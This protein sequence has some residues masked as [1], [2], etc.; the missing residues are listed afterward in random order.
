MDTDEVQD[1]FLSELSEGIEFDSEDYE[2][3]YDFDD[4]DKEEGKRKEERKEEMPLYESGTSS[5]AKD[6]TPPKLK[7][8]IGCV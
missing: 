7:K 5:V 8:F 3:E 2:D 1:M 4:E 6:H